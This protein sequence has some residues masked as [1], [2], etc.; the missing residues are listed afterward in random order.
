MKKIFIMFLFAGLL[1]AQVMGIDPSSIVSHGSGYNSTS[2]VQEVVLVDSGATRIGAFSADQPLIGIAITRNAVYD[3][4]EAS[5]YVADGYHWDSTWTAS[6]LAFI[7]G[8]KR[9]INDSARTELTEIDSID[10]L[11]LYIDGIRYYIEADS[12]QYMSLLPIDMAGVKYFYI[13]FINS[14]T[15]APVA[16]T[17]P[18]TMILFYRKY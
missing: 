5:G 6:D 8:Y 10:F 18:R 16:Q 11:P 13:E 15:G 7:L 9:S 12:M 14:S 2:W 4:T 1:K 3:S 17:E